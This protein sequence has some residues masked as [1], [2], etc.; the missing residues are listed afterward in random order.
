LHQ[1]IVSTAQ[2]P[3]EEDFTSAMLELTGLNAAKPASQEAGF[4]KDLLI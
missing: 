2:F 1:Q 3:K 4:I